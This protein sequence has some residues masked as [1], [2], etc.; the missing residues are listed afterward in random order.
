ML[1]VDE[2]LS[3]LNLGINEKPRIVLVSDAL[4]EQF[5]VKIKQM[6][7]EFKD[8]IAWSYKELREFPDQFVNTKLN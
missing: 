2:Q 1:I 5:Q 3:K 7:I 8:V 4:P 6:L